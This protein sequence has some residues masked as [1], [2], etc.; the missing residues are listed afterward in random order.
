MSNVCVTERA[1]E[2]DRESVC[3]RERARER[4]REE[5]GGDGVLGECFVAIDATP[6]P[7]LLNKMFKPISS[8]LNK[9]FDPNLRFR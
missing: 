1:T 4:E 5:C 2:R 6:I 9:M 7:F 3:E 8:L